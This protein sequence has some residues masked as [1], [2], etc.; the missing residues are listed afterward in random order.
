MKNSAHS[1][2]RAERLLSKQDFQ[3][4]FDQPFK[5]THA[6]LLALFKS[7]QQAQAKLGIMIAKHIVKSAVDRNRIKRI[8]R[9]SFRHHKTVLKGFDIIVLLRGKNS[10]IQKQDKKAL[11]NETDKLWQRL[12]TT[13]KPV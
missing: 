7:N 11:R 12:T 4:V 13:S 3:S 2:S 9:E 6:S 10:L 1:F 8:I 5:I